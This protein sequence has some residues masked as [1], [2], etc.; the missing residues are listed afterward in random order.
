MIYVHIQLEVTNLF[1]LTSLTLIYLYLCVSL[2]LFSQSEENEINALF[3]KIYAGADPEVQ[4]AMN[5]S[6]TESGMYLA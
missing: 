5:K 1:A 6:F 4:R 3:Q 2:L